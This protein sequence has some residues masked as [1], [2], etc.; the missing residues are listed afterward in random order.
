MRK[1]QVSISTIDE[2]TYAVHGRVT[3]T[4]EDGNVTVVDR[5]SK[6]VATYDEALLEAQNLNENG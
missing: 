2:N 5:V 4:D 6:T 3:T 1:I